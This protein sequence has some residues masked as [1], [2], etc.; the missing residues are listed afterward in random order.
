MPL[1]SPRQLLSRFLAS[2]D[3]GRRR[4]LPRRRQRLLRLEALEGRLLLSVYAVINTADSGEGSLRQAILDAN[5]HPGPDTIIFDIPGAGA[6]TIRPTSPLPTITDPVVLDATFQPGYAGSPLIELDGSLAGPGANGL[7]ISADSSVVRGLDITGFNSAGVRL[8]GGGDRIEGCYLGTDVTGT[9]ALGNQ[10]GVSVS[11]ANNTIGGAGTGAA[12]LI[13]GNRGDGIDLNAANNLVQGNLIGTNAAGATA[14]PNGG[15]GVNVGA[16]SNTVGGTTPGA[17]NVISGNNRSGVIIASGSNSVVEG[18]YLGTDV[19]GTAAVGNGDFGVATS[20]APG[21]LIGGT[22]PGAGNVI[23]G[24]HMDGVWLGSPG[25]Q[26]QGNYIGTDATG[27]TA[28]G[29]VDSGVFLFE[30]G[31]TVGGSVP[32]AGN[33]IS[34]NNGDGVLVNSN[35]N[36]VQG[37]RIGTDATGSRALPNTG[38]GVRALEASNLIGGTTPGARNVISGNAQAG[39]AITSFGFS[40]NNQV[41][42]NYIG[43]DV[44]GT[45]AVANGTRGVYVY[46]GTAN[47][48][49]GGSAAGAGNLISGNTAEGIYLAGNNGAANDVVQGNTIGTDLTGTRALANQTGVSIPFGSNNLIGGTA[50]GAGNFISGNTLY[51][52]EITTSF[53]TGNR[54]QGNTIGTDATGTHALGNGTGVYILNVARDNTVGGTA[55]AAGNL[56]SGNRSYGIFID[57]SFTTGNVVQGNRIGTDVTGT[58]ALGNGGD[59][60]LLSNAGHNTIGGTTAAARN[61]ISANAANGVEIVGSGATGNLVEGNYI[62][63][64]ATGTD[65]LAND[66]GVALGGGIYLNGSPGNVIGGPTATP[67]TGPGNLISGNQDAGILILGSAATGN[68]IEGNLVGTDATGTA[69]LGNGLAT[70]FAGVRIGSPDNTVGGTA[71]GAG[72]VVSANGGSGIA[73]SAAGTVVQGNDVG[74]DLTGTTALGNQVNGVNINDVDIGSGTAH[75]LIGGISPAARNV[76]SGNARHGISIAGSRASGNRVQGNDIG[77]DATGRVALGNGGN[78]VALAG[79]AND[80]TIGGTAPGAANAIAFNVL[81]GVLIDTGTGNAVLRNAIFANGGQGIELLHGGNNDQ[82]A[83]VLTAASSGGGV[84]TVQGTFTGRPSTPYTLEFFANPDPSSPGQGQRF[85]AS[86]TVTTDAG[87]NASFTLSLVIDVAPG[88]FLTATAT[89]P[90]NNT[91]AFSPAVAVTGEPLWRPEQPRGLGGPPAAAAW[92]A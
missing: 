41:E 38:N 61:V 1:P 85:F 39:V 29:N 48:T 69:A 33:L 82:P 14:L 92:G 89:D 10:V 20:L 31:N 87:G 76:I 65:A 9:S 91:S 32:G 75:N 54:V 88:E 36:V 19:S 11:G 50:A 67:G 73:T 23:S 52:I 66:T 30:A 2:D 55:P 60:V 63:T 46:G 17:R 16:G 62:G 71:A 79:G 37:N 74:T 51:G 47:N 12:N 58:T 21:N 13:S 26:V 81:D 3:K 53:S 44:S 27:R 18:D 49:I 43:T 80:N 4:K 42:G 70:A 45:L 78:G 56:I 8:E 22:T 24:N 83:P 64:D 57:G 28:L 34:G 6:H 68:L 77:T 72:N 35:A 40:F 15:H 86:V 59:G 7:A 90:A 84:L 25:I 5:A